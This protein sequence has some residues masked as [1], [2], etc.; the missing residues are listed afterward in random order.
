M[1]FNL[2]EDEFCDWTTPRHDNSLIRGGSKPA[3]MIFSLGDHL[4]VGMDAP[5]KDCQS[6]SQVL[7][8]MEKFC[9]LSL[10]Y[11]QGMQINS[12]PSQAEAVHGVRQVQGLGW[13]R[14]PWDLDCAFIWTQS[15]NGISGNGWQYCNTSVIT[16]ECSVLQ[17]IKEYRERRKK[18]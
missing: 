6:E 13:L 2:K 18:S 1:E 15:G 3:K 10:V 7:W 9:S 11:L 17:I 4:S 14:S 8:C 16:M 5:G 12:E